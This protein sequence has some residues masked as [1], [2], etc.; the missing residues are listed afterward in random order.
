MWRVQEKTE[1]ALW[2]GEREGG[3][4]GCA[5]KA[6]SLFRDSN[7]YPVSN[8][9]P[10]RGSKKE[11]DKIRFS[12]KKITWSSEWTINMRVGEGLGKSLQ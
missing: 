2:E 3:R 4:E 7:L 5:H 12:F 9:E 1:Q 10:W 8:E 11:N 6:H